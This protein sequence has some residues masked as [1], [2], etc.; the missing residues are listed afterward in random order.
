MAT[1]IWLPTNAIDHLENKV[2]IFKR[3]VYQNSMEFV[4]YD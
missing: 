4:G 1:K 2:K 3:M